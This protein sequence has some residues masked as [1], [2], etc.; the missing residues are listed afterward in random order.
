MCLNV[1]KRVRG[2]E[3]EKEREGKETKKRKMI[4]VIIPWS[5]FSL[6]VPT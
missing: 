6:W 5:V 1:K 4:A 2:R 3:R